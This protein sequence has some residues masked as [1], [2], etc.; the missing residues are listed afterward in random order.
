MNMA[1]LCEVDLTEGSESGRLLE[2]L[3]EPSS[4]MSTPQVLY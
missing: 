3:V 2:R 1:A 4:D